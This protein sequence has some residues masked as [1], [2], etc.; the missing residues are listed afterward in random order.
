MRKNLNRKKRCVKDEILERNE[1]KIFVCLGQTGFIE[2]SPPIVFR[3]VLVLSPY[4]F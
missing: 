4:A 1:G 3:P 2:I